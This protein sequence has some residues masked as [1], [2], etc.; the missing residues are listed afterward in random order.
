MF[1]DL[2]ER[3][4]DGDPSG[5]M[6]RVSEIAWIRPVYDPDINPDQSPT[7]VGMRNGEQIEVQQGYEMIRQK[8]RN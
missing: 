6:I 5:I 1:I 7:L 3:R 8:L 4:E 2:T